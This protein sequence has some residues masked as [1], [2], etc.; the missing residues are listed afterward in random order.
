MV[1]LDTCASFQ[2]KMIDI[3][4]LEVINKT[5]YEEFRSKYSVAELTEGEY[6]A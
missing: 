3:K 4:V 2:Y 5:I 6:S 1:A